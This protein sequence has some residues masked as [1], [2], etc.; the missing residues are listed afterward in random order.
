MKQCSFCGDKIEE[1]PRP[2]TYCRGY[3]C[4]KHRQ[5]EKHNCAGHPKNL[6]WMRDYKET[7]SENK[8]EHQEK[9][10]KEFRC[11][12]CDRRIKP[13]YYFSSGLCRK[14]YFEGKNEPSEEIPTPKKHTWLII[15]SIIAIIVF[16]MYANS[17]TPE[18]QTTFK[19]NLSCPPGYQDLN[20]G[21]CIKILYCIDGTQFG[22]C[23]ENK[24]LYCFG[25]ELVE[26]AD[27][28]KCPLVKRRSGMS[29]EDIADF[30]DI[31]SFIEGNKKNIQE[32]VQENL[33]KLKDTYEEVSTS[34]E[35]SSQKAADYGKEIASSVSG[36]IDDEWVNEFMNIVNE[37]RARNGLY[38]MQESTQLNEIANA[39]FIKMQ[40]KPFISHYGAEEYNVGEVIFFPDGT[41]PEEQIRDIRNDAPLHWNLLMYQTFS[42]YGY[43]IEEG[44][45]LGIYEPC[46][47]TEIPGPYIDEKEF[48]AEQGCRTTTHSSTWFVIEMY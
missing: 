28:C 9:I 13:K 20:V 25:G 36:E 2:C 4:T 22:S 35:S 16:L 39:R 17:N 19:S 3:F 6:H 34:V 40:E 12:N 38:Q 44:P 8:Q 47:V 5:P 48:F 21:K 30:S 32:S 24:P 18:K 10:I 26:R 11:K 41:T 15:L 43:H 29:C 31:M 37:E 23:S 14:C 42:A 7:K 33:Y 27:L 46:P 45:V 1:A